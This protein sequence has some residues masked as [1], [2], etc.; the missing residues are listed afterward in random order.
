MDTFTEFTRDL[1]GLP[2]NN[3]LSLTLDNTK[4]DKKCHNFFDKYNIL[5]ILEI[6]SILNSKRSFIRI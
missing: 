4:K 2:D 5:G 6:I 3:F 1:T